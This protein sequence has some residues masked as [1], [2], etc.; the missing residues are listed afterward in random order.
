VARKLFRIL[1]ALDDIDD[2]QNVYSNEDI[3]DPILAELD[4]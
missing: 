4:D 1:E 2:V 3:P